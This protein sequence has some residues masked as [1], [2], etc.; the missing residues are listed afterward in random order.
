MVFAILHFVDILNP[1][2]LFFLG[3]IFLQA[4]KSICWKDR[5]WVKASVFQGKILFYVGVKSLLNN[6]TLSLARDSRNDS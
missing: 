3:G 5:Y 2:S 6:E 1:V 4:D